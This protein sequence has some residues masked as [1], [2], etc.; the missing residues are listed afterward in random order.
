MDV[1]DWDVILY[2]V[3]FHNTP[4]GKREGAGRPPKFFVKENRDRF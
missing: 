1:R 3:E 2:F 4:W